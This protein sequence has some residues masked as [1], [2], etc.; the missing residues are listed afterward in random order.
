[1]LTG[2]ARR[3]LFVT[4]ALVLALALGLF[5]TYLA[6]GRSLEAVVRLLTLPQCLIAYVIGGAILICLILHRA[7]RQDDYYD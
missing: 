5:G 4:A 3:A 1:M 2:R 7:L 6:N